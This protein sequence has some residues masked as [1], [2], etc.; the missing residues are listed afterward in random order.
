MK[1]KSKNIRFCIC[2]LTLMLS[3]LGC[4]SDS[5]WI[6]NKKLMGKAPSEMSMPVGL[7][8]ENIETTDYT[9]LVYVKRAKVLNKPMWPLIYFS[10]YLNHLYEAEVIETFNGPEYK[11][12]LYSV[13][14]EAD[15]EPHLDGYPIVVSLCGS[16]EKGYYVPDNGYKSA[17]SEALINSGRAFKSKKKPVKKNKS[18]CD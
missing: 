4:S 3:V 10:D 6:I 8:N 17:A 7:F 13:M 14:A 9:A 12:I 16:L 18:V 15:I 1:L 5:D 2:V 11:K